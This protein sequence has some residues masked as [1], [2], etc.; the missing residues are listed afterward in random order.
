VIQLIAAEKCLK[1][2]DKNLNNVA[3]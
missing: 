2:R 1:L 3:K